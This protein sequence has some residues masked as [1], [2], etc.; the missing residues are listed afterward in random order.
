MSVHQRERDVKR[1]YDQLGDFSENEEPAVLD[2]RK[3]IEVI[4]EAKVANFSLINLNMKDK[5]VFNLAP[6][7]NHITVEGLSNINVNLKV[8]FSNIT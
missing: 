3:F 8:N 7:I 2:Q 5:F 1:S 4:T 6:T